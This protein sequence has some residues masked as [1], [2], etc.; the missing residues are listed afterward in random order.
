MFL[1]F[2]NRE[3]PFWIILT[4]FW[5][6]TGPAWAGED[7]NFQVWL[8]S[9]QEEAL[10]RGISQATVNKTLTQITLLPRVLELDSRQPEFALTLNGYLE[11]VAPE[12]RVQEGREKWLEH[13]TL[14]TGISRRYG[15]QPRF[16]IALWG[17][18]TRY[19]Q[20]NGRYSVIDAL[21]TLS[22]QG[23]RSTFFRR[24]L[25]AVLFLV[26]QGLLDPENLRGSWAGALGLFQFMPSSIRRFG[27]DFDGDGQIDL[28]GTPG[29]AMASA[30]NYLTKCGWKKDQ[31]WGM[32]VSVPHSLNRKWIGLSRQK[33]VSQWRIM[34][35]RDSQGH[36]LPNKGNDLASLIQPEGA[37]GPTFL[38]FHNYRVLLK[39]NRSHLFALAVGIL[40]DRLDVP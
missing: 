10:S 18:E 26:D 22:Y 23:R 8:Q 38:V 15:V 32:E 12:V 14:L 28:S 29:D 27:V 24:E 9:L 21:A 40:A 6:Y 36:P 33:K 35:L 11:T 25:F 3:R 7:L 2:L 5:L 4:L 1:R 17:V 34:G 30:A 20:R 39:W 31:T 37:E 19:G 16:L 13:Q